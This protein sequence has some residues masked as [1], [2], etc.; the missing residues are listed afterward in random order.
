MDRVLALPYSAPIAP[1]RPADSGEV[2]FGG[3]GPHGRLPNFT[4]KG[5]CTMRLSSAYPRRS[6][7]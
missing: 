2:G 6:R 3:L 4:A 7:V 1:S 5:S